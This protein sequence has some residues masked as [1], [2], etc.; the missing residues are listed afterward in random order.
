MECY[1]KL[2]ERL[3]EFLSAQSLEDLAEASTEQSVWSFA[4]LLVALLAMLGFVVSVIT[5]VPELYQSHCIDPKPEVRENSIGFGVER[6]LL[7]DSQNVEHVATITA[8]MH[9]I[10]VSCCDTGC[11]PNNE[12]VAMSTEEMVPN[13]DRSCLVGC[14]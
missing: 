2:P 7:C 13:N 9:P 6:D 4:P 10:D 8:E 14:C 1:N 11:L 3:D 12:H 5:P